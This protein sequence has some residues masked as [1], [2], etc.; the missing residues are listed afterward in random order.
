MKHPVGEPPSVTTIDTIDWMWQH[1]QRA[2]AVGMGN[3]SCCRFGHKL[4]V[5]G[6]ERTIACDKIRCTRVLDLMHAS[7][8]AKLRMALSE[9]EAHEAHARV[10]NSFDDVRV[11]PPKCRDSPHAAPARDSRK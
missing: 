11:W 4:T 7:R 2:T 6:V 3:F 8:V 9:G 10:R 1:T 5:D